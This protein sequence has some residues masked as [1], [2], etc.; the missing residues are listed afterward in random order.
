M[1][2]PGAWFVK[3]DSEDVNKIEDL[4]G[5]KVGVIAGGVDIDMYNDADLYEKLNRLYIQM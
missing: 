5:K 3:E 1:Y 2:S 4:Y